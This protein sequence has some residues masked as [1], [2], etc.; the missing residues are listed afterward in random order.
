MSA[1]QSWPCLIAD[2][3]VESQQGG[4][5]CDSLLANHRSSSEKYIRGMSRSA[6]YPYIGLV[7]ID[8]GM[9]ACLTQIIKS[10]VCM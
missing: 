5:A 9:S 7:A 6:H 3:I 2:T 4:L 8:H 10:A 1:T